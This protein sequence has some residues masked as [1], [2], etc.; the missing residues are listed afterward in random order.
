M[1]RIYHI[2]SLYVVL[3][4]VA[5]GCNNM[6]SDVPAEGRVTYDIH[7]SG[8]LREG[9]FVG[10]FL[11]RSIDGVFNETG[12]KLSTSVGF[13]M[14]KGDLVATKDD[15][16][17]AIDFD[18]QKLLIPLD[19]YLSK[20]VIHYDEANIKITYNDNFENVG[21]YDSKSLTSTFLLPDGKNARI[22]VYYVPDE[23]KNVRIGNAEI[24]PI[25]PGLPTAINIVADKSNVMLVLSHLS[26]KEVD[27]TVF[28]RPVGFRP[29][30]PED[31]KA[32]IS[33]IAAY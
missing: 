4:L 5:A 25:I 29:A 21:G 1:E 32:M 2:L 19:Q 23:S 33:Q 10:R 20:D 28:T 18:S 27:N 13:G 14:V 24:L 11:P 6:S 16:F 7:Y 3:L 31:L 26:E 9:S 15:G 12:M 8:D 22:D 30:A 17:I